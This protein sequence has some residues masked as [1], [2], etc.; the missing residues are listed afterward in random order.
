MLLSS[1]EMKQKM[2]L[3]VGWAVLSAVTFSWTTWASGH[4]PSV[5]EQMQNGDT[6]SVRAQIEAVELSGAQVRVGYS[7]TGAL[8]NGTQ[9]TTLCE[10]LVGSSSGLATGVESD[11][12]RAAFLQE[13]VALLKEAL[14]SKEDVRLSLSG[15][16][17]NCLQTIRIGQK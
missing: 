11:A 6:G 3:F 17:G 10:D 12:R 7:T 5:W 9:F 14:R 16:W 2:F 1:D 13:R 15:P 8:D 4:A